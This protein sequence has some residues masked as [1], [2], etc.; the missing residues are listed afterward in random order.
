MRI[1]AIACALFYGLVPSRLYE[2]TPHYA[3]LT[4]MQHL[5][6]NIAYAFRWLSLRETAEDRQFEREVNRN[7]AAR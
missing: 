5:G 1:R 3:P 2:R 7:F 6:M 4:Y